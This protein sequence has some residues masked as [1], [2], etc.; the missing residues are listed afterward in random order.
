MNRED[1]G[2]RKRGRLFI[3]IE[4]RKEKQV[5]V[6][7]VEANNYR[8]VYTIPIING[9]GTFRVDGISF[10]VLKI[11]SSID[12]AC[13]LYYP[14]NTILFEKSNYVHKLTLIDRRK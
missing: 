10:G 2:C 14:A 4:S 8:D 9:K 13:T 1:C 3:Q 7:L 6:M 5:K 11:N 12:H